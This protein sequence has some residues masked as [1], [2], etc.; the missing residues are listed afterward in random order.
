M[1][2]RIYPH[3]RAKGVLKPYLLPSNLSVTEKFIPQQV[4]LQYHTA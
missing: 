3:A 4:F 1:A 2:L